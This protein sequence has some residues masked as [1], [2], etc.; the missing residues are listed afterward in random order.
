MFQSPLYLA[1]EIA[2]R[3]PA[4]DSDDG[5]RVWI[6]FLP[7]DCSLLLLG[8]H[9]GWDAIWDIVGEDNHRAESGSHKAKSNAAETRNV[10]MHQWWK[11]SGSCLTYNP[12]RVLK[13]AFVFRP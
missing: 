8:E 6:H 3:T 10:R 2:A 7:L 12:T 9:I 4:Y 5:N 1:A 13:F 11:D